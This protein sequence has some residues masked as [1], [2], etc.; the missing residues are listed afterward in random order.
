MNVRSARIE[1]VDGVA[2]I[3]PAANLQPARVGHERLICRIPAEHSQSHWLCLARG[4]HGPA[5]CS[6]ARDAGSEE[7][8]FPYACRTLS[9]RMVDVT[10]HACMQGRGG[11]QGEKLQHACWLG[12]SPA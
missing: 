7:K 10:T 12:R 5:V 4:Q 6:L 1:V 3:H 9:C 8:R 2:C 11:G